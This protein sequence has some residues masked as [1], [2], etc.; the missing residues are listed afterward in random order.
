MIHINLEHTNTSIPF[1]CEKNKKL[2]QL[3]I[4]DIYALTFIFVV[5]NIISATQDIV[6]GKITTKNSLEYNLLKRK[7]NFC[8]IN[9]FR[10]LEFR[11][12]N[13]VYMILNLT[14]YST[15]KL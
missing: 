2:T 11:A 8:L 7:T 9:F 14:V 13:K 15:L 1:F 12:I 4:L 3:F 10:R 5:I 6:L